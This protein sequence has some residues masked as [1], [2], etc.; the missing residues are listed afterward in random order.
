MSSYGIVLKRSG[1]LRSNF[2]GYRCF[3]EIC[4]NRDNR[5]CISTYWQNKCVAKTWLHR[6][7]I[8]R[9]RVCAESVKCAVDFGD[10]HCASVHMHGREITEIICVN[11]KSWT[12]L[13][14]LFMSTQTVHE[15]LLIYLHTYNHAGDYLKFN[16]REKELSNTNSSRE[17]KAGFNRSHKE[18]RNF[19]A[20][21]QR[22]RCSEI[23]AK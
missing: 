15:M 11:I 20:A 17:I 18:S 1:S 23:S 6:N 3:G 22:R 14:E 13:T 7:F 12:I 21:S 8:S 5:F 19:S 2:H 16:V 4:L 9:Y 10:S